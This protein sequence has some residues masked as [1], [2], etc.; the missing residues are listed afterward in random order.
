MRDIRQLIREAEALLG[1]QT[2]EQKQEIIGLVRGA[3]V[4]SGPLLE[5]D[6]LSL[7]QHDG[8]ADPFG[9]VS[10]PRED[11][12][13]AHCNSFLQEILSLLTPPG[14]TV[15]GSITF[16]SLHLRGAY[17]FKL[18]PRELEIPGNRGG[19]FPM[20]IPLELVSLRPEGG[21]LLWGYMSERVPRGEIDPS[22]EGASRIID[23]VRFRAVLPTER[24]TVRWESSQPA[25]GALA[26][27]TAGPSTDTW[28]SDYNPKEGPG[29][30]RFVQG[31]LV[32]AASQLRNRLLEVLRGHEPWPGP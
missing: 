24:G 6:I 17:E 15:R 32:K 8:H 23:E 26:S 14:G 28:P 30:R 9:E 22:G 12:V 27:V 3:E 20:V 21:S 18:I 25:R 31:F 16:G 11:E 19:V 2:L 10:L 4:K 5:G 7:Y 1:R 13:M 29:H